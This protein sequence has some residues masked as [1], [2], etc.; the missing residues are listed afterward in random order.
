MH[1]YY[2]KEIWDINLIIRKNYIETQNSYRS[3]TLTN[4]NHT[5]PRTASC[6]LC[7]SMKSNTSGFLSWNFQKIFSG[8]LKPPLNTS[9]FKNNIWGSY[10][11]PP[12]VI[13]KL[14]ITANFCQ[15]H[16]LNYNSA[17]HKLDGCIKQF[18][19]CMDT[20]KKRYEI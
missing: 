10:K 14:I 5:F 3:Y 20:T 18:R 6:R 7:L 9:F 11:P 12:Y 8:G 1:G 4:F 17:Q 13:Y 19:K 2:K 16:M 15:T